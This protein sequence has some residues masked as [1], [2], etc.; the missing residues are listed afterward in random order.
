[1][2]WLELDDRILEHPKFIRAVKLSGSDAIHLWLGLRAYCGQLLTD[3]LIPNDM[4]SEVR[5]PKE[6]RRRA[7]ALATLLEVVLLDRVE[8]GL[9]MHD[10][11]DWSASRIEILKRRESA[12]DRQ[13]RSRGGAQAVTRDSHDS[14]RA[15]TDPRARG[16]APLRSAP[17]L[18]D[19]EGERGALRAAPRFVVPGTVW[20]GAEWLRRFGFAWTAQYQQASYRDAGDGT[21]E[22][23]LD[24]LLN[25]IPTEELLVTQENAPR[26]LAEFLASSDGRTVSR[27]HPFSFFVQ[28]WAG[29]RVEKRNADWPISHAERKRQ[30]D[31]EE[32]ARRSEAEQKATDDRLQRM[33][34]TPEMS[35]ADLAAMR[36][37]IRSLA[38]QKAAVG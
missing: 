15:V 24:A 1:M 33:R 5:G 35:P 6:P 38:D 26:M 34:D 27:R 19:P 2:S 30:A 16:S 22:R 37:D 32:A 12:R 28:E 9:M 31:R 7:S 29:L 23:K 10:Y 13:R 8:N 20:S 18:T 14:S 21:A 4:I 36:E 11:L 25:G 3:G 17:L